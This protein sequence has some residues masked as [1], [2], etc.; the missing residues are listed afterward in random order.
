MTMVA[1]VAA[2][3]RMAIVARVAFMAALREHGW[4]ARV[5]SGGNDTT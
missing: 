2:R 5:P 3:S 1:R 4:L